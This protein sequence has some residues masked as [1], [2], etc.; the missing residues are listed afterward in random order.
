MQPFPDALEPEASGPLAGVRVLDLTRV[1]AGNALTVALADFGADVIKIEPPRGDD[2]RNWRVKGVSTHWKVLARNKRS[3][4]LNLRDERAK[5]ALL[6]L[7]AGAQVLVENFRPGVMEDMG[8]GP[9][10]L[11]AVNPA[12]IV[13][14]VSG[15]GQTGPF[16]HKPGFGSLIEGLSGFAAING[17]ADRPP[18]LPPLALADQIAGLN[19]AIATLVAL[20]E[21][22]VNGG[23]GQVLDLSL[24]EPI[25][26]TLSAQAANYKL[27]GAPAPRTGNASTTT[28]PRGVYATKDERWVA[29]SASTQGMTEKLLRT[30][31]KAH[32]LEDPRFLTNADRV[33]NVEALDAEVGGWI[34]AHTLDEN[35]AIFEAAGVTVGAVAD[36]SELVDHPLIRE[37]GIIVEI[38]DPEMGAC[39]MP[40]I[41]ARLSE[42]PGAIRRAAP[43]IG[44]HTGELLGEIGLAPADLARLQADG[45]IAGYTDPDA[46]PGGNEET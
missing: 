12:L 19:G 24:F 35:L 28:A 38:P 13:V 40:A 30:I 20:R 21:I 5:D 23:R 7:A 1:V 6:K 37:R 42:T 41:A 16:R 43:S 31:G 32:L 18:L 39:P 15:W 26:S 2:L 45:A 29:L 46:G 44:E 10:R 4:A 11:H 3:V 33:A 9:E 34:G 36:I 22:E 8:L 14:R 27:E 25:F 17:F